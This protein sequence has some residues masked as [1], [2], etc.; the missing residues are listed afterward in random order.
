MPEEGLEP[1]DTRIMI[2]HVVAAYRPQPRA[3]ASF[4]SG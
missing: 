3:I 2:P 1:P 4:P